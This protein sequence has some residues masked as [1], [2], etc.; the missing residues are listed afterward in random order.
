MYAEAKVLL[1]NWTGLLAAVR[2]V[3][4]DGHRATAHTLF[5]QAR[6]CVYAGACADKPGAAILSPDGKK[7]TCAKI[8]R[9]ECVDATSFGK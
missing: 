4:L 9:D 5:A 7:L 2:G 3:L 6:A 1:A 8:K